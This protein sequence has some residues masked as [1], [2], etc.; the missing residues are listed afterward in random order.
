MGGRN[1]IIRDVY[2]VPA[3]RLLLFSNC[4]HRRVLG[5]GYHSD[6]ESVLVFSPSFS[7]EVDD[8][9][10]DYVTCRSLGRSTRTFDYI[11]PKATIKNAS[12]G[13]D[14]RCSSRLNPPPSKNSLA[15]TSVQ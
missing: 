9:V 8:E 3:L 5:C 15:W 13:S 12:A 4:V 7:L 6:N 2:H 11:Q 10:D 14:P 1:V